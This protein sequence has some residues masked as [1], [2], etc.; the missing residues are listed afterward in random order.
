MFEYQVEHLFSYGATLQAPPELIGPV[1]EGIRATFY[2]TGGIVRGQRLRGRLRPVGGDWFLVRRDGVGVLD[3]RATIETE[4]GALIDLAYRG[5]GDLGQDGY[6]QFLRGKLPRKL[7]LRTSP[8]LRT[9]H[10]DYQW[11]QRLHCVAVGEADLERFDVSYDVYA[12]R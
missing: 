4:D 1:P 5:L 2:V 3:V 10:P 8:V 11:L 12:V 6:E 9:S 7:P